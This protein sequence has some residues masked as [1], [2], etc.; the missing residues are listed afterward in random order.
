MKVKK[1][2]GTNYYLTPKKLDK[3]LEINE[4]TSKAL[5]QIRDD[6]CKSINELFEKANKEHRIYK[7]VL[8]FPD[9]DDIRTKLEWEVEIPEIHICKVSY[10]WIP[11]FEKTERYGSFSDFKKFY[12]EYKNDFDLTDEYNKH[13]TIDELEEI[14]TTAKEKA[15]ES[16]TKYDSPY[17]HIEV[18]KDGFEWS[19]THFS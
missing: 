1:I 9:T 6:Y 5:N 16:H 2:M 15:Q 14:V 11:L 3:I 18:D 19:S 10:G 7:E 17:Y 13:L 8:D 12:E 4:I